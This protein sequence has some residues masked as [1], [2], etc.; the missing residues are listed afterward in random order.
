MVLPLG[1]QFVG[2]LRLSGLGLLCYSYG[3]MLF[4]ED[5]L[6]IRPHY[7]IAMRHAIR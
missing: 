4:Y 5:M 6:F 3:V 1:W 7:L 2:W